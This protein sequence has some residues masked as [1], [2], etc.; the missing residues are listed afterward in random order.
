MK[1]RVACHIEVWRSETPFRISR[2]T[3]YE[4]PAVVCA[5]EQ[6]GYIGRGEA[7]GVYY[8]GETEQTM[9][10]QLESIADALRDGADRR[11]L[12]NMLPPGGARCAADAALWDLDAQLSG[13]SA[14]QAA[15]VDAAPVLSTMTIGLENEP[16]DMAAKAVRHA[17][18]P[19]LKIKL[20]NDRPVERIEAIRRVRRDARLIVDVNEGWSFDELTQYAPQLAG[21]GVELI[22]Q[23]LPR[24]DDR[25]LED[26]DSPLPLCADE[27]C[28]HI[29]E[30]EAAARRYQLI[31]IKLDKCGGLTH[32]L[33]IAAA[34]RELGKGI[35][36]GCM[37]GTSLAM[38][39]HHV[40]SQLAE[41]A[42]IDG[43]M[44]LTNDRLDG[45]IY[46]DGLVSL[47]DQRLWG[48]QAV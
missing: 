9:L 11:A 35:F 25:V 23:P 39:P 45:F 22:E 19:L 37:C 1:R 29:G 40:I 26:Y 20:N 41:F 34:I 38:A 21:L 36:V 42:D 2:H 17:D 4:Y 28:Q 5:I 33:E 48:R 6:D 16:D 32:G 24:G 30:L 27:S 10:G 44:L 14:W 7:L 46:K 3:S 12:L 15:G 8:R 47:P 18:F 43:P 13:I 31:N